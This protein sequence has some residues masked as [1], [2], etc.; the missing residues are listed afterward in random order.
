MAAL[1]VGRLELCR[2]AGRERVAFQADGISPLRKKLEQ[3]P[4]GTTFRLTI[5][6]NEDRL[7][8]VVRVVNEGAIEGG[9]TIEVAH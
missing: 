8:P 2:H 7:Q 5:L 1:A 3:Y 9:L 6:G 4:S